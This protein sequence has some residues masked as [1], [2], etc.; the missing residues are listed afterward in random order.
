MLMIGFIKGMEI[1]VDIEYINH[2]NNISILLNS[3]L[4]KDELIVYRQKRKKE[5]IAYFYAIWSKKEAYS[6]AIGKG[7]N[8]DF[9]TLNLEQTKYSHLNSG[10]K[11][12]FS[13]TY[14]I[15]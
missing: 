1:G 5:K 3:V 8:V 2:Q 14:C 13:W 9:N 11:N 7:L 4:T 12:S 15:L 6:K 10:I